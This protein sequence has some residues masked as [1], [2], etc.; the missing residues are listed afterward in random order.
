MGPRRCLPPLELLRGTRPM[1]AARSRPDLNALGSVM[2]AASAVASMTP[3]P[4]MVS[5]RRLAGHWRCWACR[6]LSRVSICA[7]KA[8]IWLASSFRLA[9]ASCGKR[10]SLASARIANSRQR[11]C[12]PVA[13]TSPNS[14]MCA[15][16]AL[17]VGVR[18][19]SSRSRTNPVL[20]RSPLLLG[21]LER[22]K[23]H[24]RTAH[25]L[26][27]R[28]RVRRIGLVALHIGLHVPR[29]HQPN[30]VAEL[31]ELARPVMRPRAR[32][33]PDQAWRQLGEGGEHLAAPQLLL[34]HH[35]PLGTDAVRLKHV[36][37]EIQT[38]RAN[39]HVDGS[40]MVIRS[41]RPPYGTSM[42]GAGAVHLIRARSWLRWPS[43]VTAS[44]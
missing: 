27:D 21:R 3:M 24:R 6:R 16:S 5:S 28:R 17:M 20:H 39:L 11:P 22:H 40:L 29:W 1:K 19:R 33:H 8:A 30:V 42:P 23:A 36:L 2:V 31:P 14:A 44:R 41:T 43:G 4:G 32:F 15:R 25:R 35:L 38:D 13:A 37:G 9:R 10:S 34:Q 26:A 12:L 7:C 18:C